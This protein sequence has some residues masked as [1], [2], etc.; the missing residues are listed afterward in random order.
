MRHNKVLK[1]H[2]SD[3]LDGPLSIPPVLYFLLFL[4]ATILFF[5][6]TQNMRPVT[7]LKEAYQDSLHKTL[8]G[9]QTKIFTKPTKLTKT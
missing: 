8:S 3:S 7:I 4:I 9:V 5:M 2:L 1:V 6:D